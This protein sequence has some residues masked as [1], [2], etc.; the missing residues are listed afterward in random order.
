MRQPTAAALL[1]AVVKDQLAQQGA[2]E[3]GNSFWA[4]KLAEQ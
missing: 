1:N 4:A 3:A 2:I